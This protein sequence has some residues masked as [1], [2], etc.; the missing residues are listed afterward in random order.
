MSYSE[1]KNKF[2]KN[3]PKNAGSWNSTV[4]HKIKLLKR[5]ITYKMSLNNQNMIPYSSTRITVLRFRTK[6]ELFFIIATYYN[7]KYKITYRNSY[8]RVSFIVIPAENDYL[9]ENIL[10]K[11]I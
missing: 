4:S 3:F 9:L 7:E 11:N 10:L 6:V 1:N 8:P 2:H 5:F